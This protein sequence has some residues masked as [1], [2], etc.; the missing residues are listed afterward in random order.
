MSTK[1]RDVK[2]KRGT[3]PATRL[4]GET[5]LG[6]VYVSSGYGYNTRQAFIEIEMPGQPVVQFGVDEARIIAHLIL[7]ACE[8]AEQDGA[9]TEWIQATYDQEPPEARGRIAAGLLSEIRAFRNK[10]REQAKTKS[11]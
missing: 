6:Q 11:A 7:E 9:I 3:G 10:R 5:T 2:P 4:P 1:G 8:A